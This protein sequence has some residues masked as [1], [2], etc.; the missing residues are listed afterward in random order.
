MR[1]N[2]AR[3]YARLM[4]NKYPDFTWQATR[5]A[6]ND[7]TVSGSDGVVT[8]HYDLLDCIVSL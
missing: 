8:K 2:T 7:W 5:R 4:A 3:K 1:A 6:A